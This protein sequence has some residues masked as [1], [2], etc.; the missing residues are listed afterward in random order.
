MPVFSHVDE[1]AGFLRRLIGEVADDPSA[2]RMIGVT[3]PGDAIKDLPQ[4][5]FMANALPRSGL[6][7]AG[8]GIAMIHPE[9]VIASRYGDLSDSALSRLTGSPL[10]VDRRGVE[11]YIP[12]YLQPGTE[13]GGSAARYVMPRQP[14][15][16]HIVP[17]TGFIQGNT[18]YDEAKFF[19]MLVHE[20]RHA[21]TRPEVLRSRASR[22]LTSVVS[23]SISELSVNRGNPSQKYK[24]YLSMPAE[25]VTYLGEAGD[26][27]ARATGRLAQTTDD[28]EQAL[29]M[30][31]NNGQH[32]ISQ[33]RSGFYLDAYRSSPSARKQIV[34]V[35]T[36]VLG[37]PGAVAVGASQDQP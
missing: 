34:D 1:A 19:R 26:D 31:A 30:M 12:V 20:L 37:V 6:P 23:P 5:E 32:L 4:G 29:E 16:E 9:H 25:Q 35:M 7:P 33:P 22:S 27:F 36:R 18:D 15:A 21:T 2:V 13:T 11:P 24:S 3:K 8:T 14:I 28:V 17:E 10:Q